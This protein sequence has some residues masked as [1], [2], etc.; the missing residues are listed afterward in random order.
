MNPFKLHARRFAHVYL[1]IQQ[2]LISELILILFTTH[3]SEVVAK[4][5]LHVAKWSLS[6]FI[7]TPF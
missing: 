5:N 3:F 4:R 1:N 7:Q 6:Y 2:V